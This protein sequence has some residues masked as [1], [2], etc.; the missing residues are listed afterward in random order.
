LCLFVNWKAASLA[1]YADWTAG[2]HKIFKH[3]QDLKLAHSVLQ[4]SWDTWVLTAAAASL[5]WVMW[6]RHKRLL[7]M[8]SPSTHHIRANSETGVGWDF[9]AAC[10]VVP[11]KLFCNIHSMAVMAFFIAWPWWHLGSVFTNESFLRR[12]EL[13][14]KK[15]AWN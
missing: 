10:K 8:Q 9:V 13:Q 15:Y 4:L 5:A 2:L 12:S 6:R 3:A 1:W 7:R 11:F 14:P